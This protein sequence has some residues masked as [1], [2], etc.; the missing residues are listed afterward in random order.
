[1]PTY[2]KRTKVA[3]DRSRS[4]IER[5]LTRYGATGFMYGWSESGSVIG[6]M[7]KGKQYRVSVK[8]P[9]MDEYQPNAIGARRTAPQMKSS[10]ESATR[11]R[12]RALA[13]V[14]KAKLE[15]VESEISTVEIEFLPWMVLPNGQTV[16]QWLLPQIEAIQSTGKM[17]PLLPGGEFVD[18][19]EV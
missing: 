4:E 12:F 14:I 16:G 9:K 18:G 3:P 5:T 11:Q 2:A 10:F 8:L 13:L 7:M 1:M 19:E 6:F 15:A 17:P